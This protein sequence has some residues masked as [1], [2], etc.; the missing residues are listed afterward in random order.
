[1]LGRVFQGFGAISLVMGIMVAAGSAGDCDGKC[2]EYANTLPEMLL[3][4]GIGLILMLGG[5]FCIMA[6]T[7][8]RSE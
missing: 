5:A 3:I 8:I 6:G 2:M 4:A 1:M 7:A